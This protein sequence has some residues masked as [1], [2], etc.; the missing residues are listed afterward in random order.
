VALLGT[1]FRF[2]VKSYPYALMRQF[3]LR[4]DAFLVASLAVGGVRAAGVYSI[5]A[6]LA[7]LLIFIPES[8]RLSLFPMVAA[9]SPTEANRLTLIACRHT[10]LLTLICIV[11]MAALGP[12]AITY[13]YGKQFVGAVI[14]LLI[15]LP[16]VGMLA[17]SHLL[18]GDLT[19]RG[20]PEATTISALCSLMVTIVLDLLLIPRYG[21]IGAAIASACAYT[22]ECMVNTFFFIRHSGVSWRDMFALQ[23]SDLLY[24]V[25]FVRGALT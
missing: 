21:I 17:L 8:I 7:E 18:E 23:K 15:L 22:V 20:R 14:P 25:S 4:L 19:G 1:S 16:G 3:N 9:S 6:G 13:I 24:Y 2:G 5:A 12:F 10:L 11:V